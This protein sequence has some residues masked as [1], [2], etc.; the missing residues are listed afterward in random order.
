MKKCPYC[1]EEIQD[2]ARVCRYCNRDLTAP[3]D[4][5]GT[6]PPAEAKTSGKAVASLIISFL[7]IFFIPGVVAVVLGHIARSEIKKAA[8]ELKGEG[9]ALAGLIIGYLGIAAIPFLLIIAAIAIPN[10][11]RARSAANEASAVGSLR[12]LNMAIE[13]YSATYEKGVP[14]DPAALG[15]ST[16]GGAS[17][18]DAAG[19]I[20]SALAS[21][22]KSGY[23]FTYTVTGMNPDGFPNTYTITADPVKPGNTGG[24]YF[25]TD[26]TGMIRVDAAQQASKESPPIM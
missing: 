10:L 5:S 15:T 6:A 2:E 11:L 3:P 7:S 25:F 18:A 26:E 17:E 4:P 9:I 24:R 22:Q 19:L 13:T 14:P 12:T 20:D 23:V 1:A 8:G 21:G 16:S